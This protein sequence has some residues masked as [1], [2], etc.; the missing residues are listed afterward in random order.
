MRGSSYKSFDFYVDA[1]ARPGGLSY[2]AE[3]T[4]VHDVRFIGHV[5]ASGS[6]TFEKV[7]TDA[8]VRA[9]RRAR[10]AFRAKTKK[11]AGRVGQAGIVSVPALA[12]K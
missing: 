7:I 11:S 9:K 12:D 8:N 4:K 2:Y 5:I 3:R 10:V 6:L 1:R